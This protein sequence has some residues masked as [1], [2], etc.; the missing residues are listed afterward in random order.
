M[1]P[2]LADHGVAVLQSAGGD[3][4]GS[5]RIV[6]RLQHESGEF[7][8]SEPLEIQIQNDRNLAQGA[9]SVITYG[10]R[11]QVLA[12]LGIAGDDDDDGNGAGAKDGGDGKPAAARPKPKPKPKPQTKTK[13]ELF[14]LLDASCADHGIPTSAVKAA[15][16]DRYKRPDSSSLTKPEIQES[17]DELDKFV[18]HARNFVADNGGLLD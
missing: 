8:Q 1:R 17:L 12:M 15:L 16:L 6:T 18:T 2:V 7:I 9:G 14:D 10:R 13:K 5:A 11:Y 3:G 4:N